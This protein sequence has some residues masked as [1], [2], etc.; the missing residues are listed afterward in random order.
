[1]SSGKAKGPRCG[2]FAFMWGLV[3]AGSLLWMGLAEA[4]ELPLLLAERYRGGVDVSRYWASEKLDGV[5]AHWDGRQLRFRSGNSV[6]APRWFVAALPEQALDGELW[7][8]RGTFDQ[9]SSIVRRDSPND[10]EWRRVRYMVFELPDAPGTFTERIERMKQLAGGG[11]PPWLTFVEQFRLGDDKALQGMLTEVVRQGGEGLMLHRADAL[12]EAGR[13]PVLLKVTP[14]LDAEAR[15]VAHLPGKG[16]YVGMTGALR[17]E[18]PDGHRFALGSGLTD[19]QR[20]HPP[21]IGALVTYPYRELG[22]NGI[23][24]FA[25]FLRV[26]DVF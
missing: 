25:R 24:R 21:A 2:P 19:E 13:S 14:W 3:V 23:P 17:V 9:L 10:A 18:M 6:P 8:G 12:Y 1:M 15:V 20:R 16:K 4:A 5:R 7:L 22:R 11:V 26:R